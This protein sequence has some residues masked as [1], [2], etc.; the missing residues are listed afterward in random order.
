[1]NSGRICRKRSRRPEADGRRSPRPRPRS[2]TRSTR[3]ARALVGCLALRR[4]GGAFEIGRTELGKLFLTRPGPHVA[5][6]LSDLHRNQ[7]GS[8]EAECNV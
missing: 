2:L 8:F 7:R 3:T 6:M 1:M 4:G 5:N